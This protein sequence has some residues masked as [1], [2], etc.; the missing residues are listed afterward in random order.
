M[1]ANQ[2]SYWQL[3]ETRRANLAKES[4]TNRANVAKEQETNRHNVVSEGQTDVD[5]A[6]KEKEYS[7]QAALNAQK[8]KESKTK[9]FQNV[10]KGIS[11]IST[12]AKNLYSVGKGIADDVSKAQSAAAFGT[13]LSLFA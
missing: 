2:L 3:Q 8:I 1:T 4:E 7:S 11:D 12:T 13:Q 5:L 10:T 6:R 9:G